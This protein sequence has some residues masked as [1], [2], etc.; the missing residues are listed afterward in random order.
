MVSLSVSIRVGQLMLGYRK[1]LQA[2]SN[3]FEHM[4]Q[5]ISV[6]VTSVFGQNGPVSVGVRQ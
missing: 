4:A 6:R 5:I 3:I 1:T 2:F